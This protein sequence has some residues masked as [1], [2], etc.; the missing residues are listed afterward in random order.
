[1][2]QLFTPGEYAELHSLVFRDDYAGYKPNV[3]ESPNGDGVRDIEK[4]YAHVSE[5]Y[6]WP[7]TPEITEYIK[8]YGYHPN[9]DRSSLLQKYLDRA[10]DLS[11][12]VAITLGV[13]RQFWP[14]HKYSALRVLEYNDKATTAPHTD[15]D[16]FTLMCYRNLP[17]Y[18]VKLDR[19]DPLPRRST[20]DLQAQEKYKAIK[21]EDASNLILGHASQLNTQIHFGELLEEI[22]PDR[23]VATKHEV[24]ASGGPWQYSVV[25]FGIPD[26][27]SVLPSGVTVGKWLEERMSRSRYER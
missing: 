23:Y 26:W 20:Y 1:V 18:F 14:V 7:E 8:A 2:T 4:R 22:D 3:V 25:Y 11:V 17:Q 27:D 13:P 21:R 19:N 16:L 6:L 24:V 5:K 15:F 9:H 12:Q 10:H